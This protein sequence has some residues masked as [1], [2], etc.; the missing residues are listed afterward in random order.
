MTRQNTKYSYVT[1]TRRINPTPWFD[2]ALTSWGSTRAWLPKQS[3]QSIRTKY[4]SDDSKINV[5]ISKCM[6]S[7]YGVNSTDPANGNIICQYKYVTNKNSFL[8][9]APS[10]LGCQNNQSNQFRPSIIWWCQDGDT[11]TDN[12]PNVFQANA[13]HTHTRSQRQQII[14][15]NLRYS[16]GKVKNTN[17]D[18]FWLKFRI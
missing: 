3:K 14:D 8:P 2:L 1:N 13:K 4:Q 5:Q 17:K 9:E 15:C 16:L 7:K 10:E 12:I 6:S 18:I 11:Q